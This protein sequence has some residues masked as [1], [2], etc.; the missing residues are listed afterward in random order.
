MSILIN[1]NSKTNALP[2]F[3]K[4]DEYI[5]DRTDSKTYY[6]MHSKNKFLEYCFSG[7]NVDIEDTH[8]KYNTIIHSI[9]DMN[10]T[11]YEKDKLNIL[12]C[13][14]NCNY[15]KHYKHY[16]HYKNFGNLLVNIYIYNHFSKIIKN[17][18]YIVIPLIYIR[19][20]HFKLFKNTISPTL[21]TPFKNKKFCLF[22]SNN[23]FFKIG[24]I[25][26]KIG[27][28]DHIKDFPDRVKNKSCYFSVELLNLFNEYKFIFCSENSFTDGYITE[29]IFNVF[30]SKSIP[31]YVGPND[32]LRYFNKQCFININEKHTL[33]D[34]I[35]KYIYNEKLFNEKINVDKI[36]NNY[37]DENYIL[38]TNE[39][40][41]N[42]FNNKKV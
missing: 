42:F 40:I 18:N 32:T 13:H 24:P 15:H 34:T 9:Q 5:K 21:T 20:N 17:D 19:I 33:V 14:E 37:D 16:N 2:I 12:Y 36:S 26:Q 6:Q 1:S 35:E 39:F 29:K 30:F 4:N 22:T 10:M 11:N 38:L 8:N 25:L 41:M 3:L 23:D 28:C 7:I 31:I 27:Q